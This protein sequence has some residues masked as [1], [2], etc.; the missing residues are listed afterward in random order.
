[1]NGMPEMANCAPS[2]PWA[3]SATMPAAPAADGAEA[4]RRT[5]ASAHRCAADSVSVDL[6]SSDMMAPLRDRF[7]RDYA[8]ALRTAQDRMLAAQGAWA[9]TQVTAG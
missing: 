7:I 9:S 8:R 1:M 4:W 3:V 2:T 5:G 6:V